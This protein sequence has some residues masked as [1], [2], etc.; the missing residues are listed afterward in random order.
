[1]Q[2][3][4]DDARQNGFSVVC[5]QHNPF[6]AI[7]AKDCSFTAMQIVTGN[8]SLSPSWGEM[9]ESY[10][11]SV[12]AF[13][14]AGGDFI[15]WIAG[16]THRDIIST[17]SSYPNQ[18]MISVAC[19]TNKQSSGPD[20]I[21]AEGQRSQDSFNV[22]SFDTAYKTVTVCKIGQDLDDF[23]RSKQSLCVNYET[24][25]IYWND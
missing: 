8:Y 25:Q 3:V 1:M 12:D 19:A 21:R 17:H 14:Q 22:Y 9:I 7:D 20:D 5:A 18:L 2:N 6:E 16:H 15:C 10:V 13:Q 23:M 24:K 11:E 4:L